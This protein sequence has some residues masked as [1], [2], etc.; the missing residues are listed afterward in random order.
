MRRWTET[1]VAFLAA[2]VVTVACH[3]GPSKDDL[4]GSWVGTA[5]HDGEEQSVALELVPAGEGEV[6]L[7]LTLPAVHMT[8]QPVG[9]VEPVIEG[10][11]VTLG[12]FV[13]DYDAR[14]DALC[15]TIPA[16]LAP[17]YEIP[18]T[19]YR[20]ETVQPPI[21]PEPGAPLAEPAW[22]FDAGAALWPGTTFADGRV[23]AGDDAGRIHALEAATGRELWTFD[24]GGAVRAR[25]AAAAGS[26][27]FQA[28][29]GVLYR[30][31]AATGRPTWSAR[32]VDEPLARL[33][34]GDPASAWDFF[35]SGVAVAGEHLFVGT[36]D[37][38]M[39][40]LNAGDGRRVWVYST[41]GPLLASPAV[42]SGR[43]F[44]GSFDGHVHALDAETGEPLWKTDTKGAV[45]SGP[46]VAGDRVIVGNRAYDLLALDAA[47]GE[48]AWKDYIWFSWV[49]SSAAV[50]DGLAYVGSSDAAAVFAVDA[51]SGEH[52]WTSDVHGWAWG[53]PAVTEDRVYVGAAARRGYQ[54]D[55]HEGG[56]FGLD[57]STGAIVWRYAFSPP[58][59]G[60]WGVPG[61]VAV[62]AGRVFVAGLDGR[63]RAFAE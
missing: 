29:D 30:L 6:S 14:A 61:S 39:V 20:V 32:L 55:V 50:R 47:T 13:F 24:A 45:V 48:V 60:F 33:P 27:F 38:R 31:D 26:V 35:A 10:R 37:G 51:G 16:V 8:R 22:T 18:V 49:E 36:R 41:Q 34:P 9:A 12:P 46:A 25:I 3:T 19:L 21:R 40:A 63:V 56:V 7:L 59:E 2:S 42:D 17:V 15:G 43:L 54:G 4:L 53:Q 28:D 11:R 44:F 5:S 58:E 52:V 62:G 23:Y 1:G 57:R